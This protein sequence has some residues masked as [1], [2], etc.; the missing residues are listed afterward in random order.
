[1]QQDTWAP[2]R[3]QRQD[4]RRWCKGVGNKTYSYVVALRT[5]LAPVTEKK[6]RH[7]LKR[8][9]ERERALS[10]SP[11]L[12]L[13]GH[14]PR[15]GLWETRSSKRSKHVQ[16]LLWKSA[17]K[18][19][20]NEIKDFNSHTSSKTLWG[21]SVHKAMTWVCQSMRAGSYP[22]MPPDP[23]MRKFTGCPRVDGKRR[24]CSWLCIN[25]AFHM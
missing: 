6:S 7:T 12:C 15:A 5:K 10:L 4:R 11:R 23:A 3:G 13:Y 25:W 19:I 2:E 21:P 17:R 8:K 24:H 14:L 16:Q 18:L 9:G 20:R 1:M 22:A